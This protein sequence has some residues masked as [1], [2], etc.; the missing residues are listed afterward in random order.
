[1]LQMSRPGSLIQLLRHH[2][3]PLGQ[4]RRVE[5]T[6]PRGEHEVDVGEHKRGGEVQCV[7]AAQLSLRRESCRSL[8][9]VLVDLNDP[10]RRPLLFER[11]GS[12]SSSGEANRPSGL[13]EPDA[14][15]EPSVRTI[16]CATYHITS[17]LRYIAL[18]E[19]TC[20]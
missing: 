4:G 20:V 18:D 11:A 7:Q 2:C 15:H 1:M 12:R 8:D 6:I 16:H 13:D 14:A 17:R 3:Q 5:A 19:R 9:D 10:E